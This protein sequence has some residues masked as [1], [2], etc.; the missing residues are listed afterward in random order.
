M[1]KQ[2][3]QSLPKRIVY[4]D[5]LRVLATFSVIILHISAQN[6]YI[7]DVNEASWQIFNFYDSM[8][9]W[10]VPIF[11]M[12]SGAL[13]LNKRMHMKE[14]YN[15]YILRMF[16]S[17]IVWAVIYAFSEK[18][19]V[20][21]LMLRGHYHMWFIPTIIGLYLCIPFMY[22]IVQNEKLT[23]YF[24]LLAFIFAFAIP[25]IITLANDFIGEIIIKEVS[26]FKRSVGNMNINMVLGYTSYFLLGHYLNKTDLNKKQ[27]IIIYILGIFGFVLTIC[28]NLTVALKKQKPCS[29]YYG[30]FTVNVLFESVAVFTWF[31]YHEFF[32]TKIH[33]FAL[34]LSKYSFGVYLVHPLIIER[35]NRCY[36]LN[37]LS[38]H[39][40]ISV[41]CIGVIVFICSFLVS[42]ILNHVPI[43]KDY[44]V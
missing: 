13:F 9:R 10:S 5:Y 8:V 6:W 40:G 24:L 37:T 4:F 11:I 42:D 38:F 33:L 43:I 35:L 15:K 28:L 2:T 18:G 44:I 16:C 19:D 36:G 29:N 22:P 27:R 25:Q 26:A 32:S 23:K 31:K 21:A 39:P 3:F 17:F 41:V 14:I 1:E 12:I 20:V 30:N 34:K 7:V